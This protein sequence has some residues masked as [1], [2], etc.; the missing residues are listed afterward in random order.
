MTCHKYKRIVRLRGTYEIQV[1]PL[2]NVNVL[3]MHPS[4]GFME[5]PD[6]TLHHYCTFRCSHD[7][8]AREIWKRGDIPWVGADKTPFEEHL[9]VGYN[10]FY[11]Q[12][13][14]WFMH[15]ALLSLTLEHWYE[16]RTT[17]LDLSQCTCGNDAIVPK[18]LK[19]VP[20]G[21][22]V[23]SRRIAPCPLDSQ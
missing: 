22:V 18:A 19:S 5:L 21:W 1:P 8:H 20:Y 2:K 7:P 11:T 16:L 13:V 4:V 3:P 9:K 23:D 10:E 17:P 15:P 6:I 14:K 12:Y